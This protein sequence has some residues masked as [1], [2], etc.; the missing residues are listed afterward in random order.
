VTGAATADSICSLAA[1][2]RC[3]GDALMQRSPQGRTTAL[4]ER[5][6]LLAQPH[7]QWQALA[8]A[9]APPEG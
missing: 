5:D 4:L 8:P 9:P 7:A 6:G 3:I 2:E 1:V